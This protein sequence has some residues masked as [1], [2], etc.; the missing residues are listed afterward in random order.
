[1]SLDISLHEVS[2]H[3]VYEDNITHNLTKMAEALGVYKAIW[4]PEEVGIKYAKDLGT[5][6]EHKYIELLSNSKKYKQYNATNGWGMYENFC[7]FINEL[8]IACKEHP[9]AE[10]EVGR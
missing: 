9:D 1:M 6:L 2:R 4:H 5:I 7:R 8:L 3:S 10:I